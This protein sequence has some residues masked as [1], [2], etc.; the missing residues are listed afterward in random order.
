MIDSPYRNFD[1]EA[2]RQF[3]EMEERHRYAVQDVQIAYQLDM[4]RLYLRRSADIA[5][6][7]FELSKRWVAANPPK[8]IK[9]KWGVLFG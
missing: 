5:V 4:H 2:G 7:Q 3:R 1:D 8:L 6:I 9:T